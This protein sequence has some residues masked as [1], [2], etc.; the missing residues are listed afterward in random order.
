M[1]RHRLH[2]GAG[3]ARGL[4]VHSGGQAPG[5]PGALLVGGAGWDD[6]LMRLA[7]EPGDHLEVTVVVQND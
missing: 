6:P 7:S 2:A 1:T 3:V 5:V 4:W